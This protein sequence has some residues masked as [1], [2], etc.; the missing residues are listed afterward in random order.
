[1][2]VEEDLFCYLF[3]KLSLVI[4]FFFKVVSIWFFVKLCVY[5]WRVWLFGGVWVFFKFKLKYLGIIKDV[6]LYIIC[7]SKF[8][9]LLFI[10]RFLI[11]YIVKILIRIK[12]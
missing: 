9:L 3:R 11:M 2:D 7:V 4:R 10:L 12:F 8:L 1:M 5:F 6:F